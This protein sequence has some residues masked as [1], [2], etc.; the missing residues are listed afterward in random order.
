MK[1]NRH[2]RVSLGVVA[3]GIGTALG[4]LCLATGVVSAY[5]TF[6][7]RWRNGTASFAVNP[8][9]ADASA[10]AASAQIAAIRGGADEWTTNGNANFSWTYAGTTSIATIDVN[11]HVN[12]I[13]AYAADGGSTLAETY[14]ASN[15][16]G[17][18]VGID[19]RFYDNN[20]TW[21][22]GTPAGGEFDIQGVACHE[23][24]HALGLGHSSDPAATMY[25]STSAGATNLR[26]I[27]ADD[28]AGIQSI[29]GVRNPIRID[30]VIAAQGQIRGG[31]QVNVA[32]ANL[33]QSNRVFFGGVEGTVVSSPNSSSL[34]VRTPAGAALGSVD[35]EVR[36][37]SGS[38]TL[39][40]GFTYVANSPGLAYEGSTQAGRT[41]QVV[42]YG[43]P[44][45]RF[46]LVCDTDPG[47]RT[48]Q[49]LQ[50]CVGFSSAF[51]VLNDSLRRSGTGIRLDGRGEGRVPYVVP[52]DPGL[53]LQSITF[54]A[55]V[56]VGVGER[57]LAVTDCMPITVFP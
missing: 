21:A 20:R 2:C 47:P 1:T 17:E 13:Y 38:S 48:R 37:A 56:D 50:L 7:G 53:L 14:C 40:S 57:S 51:R 11:D 45:A 33:A 19:M 23:F 25:P 52:S 26:T 22:S 44:N 5:S 6:C 55:V 42:V 31:T 28:V 27:A 49:G 10:G 4:A 35:V 9:F 12:A 29:Y 32:G 8:N 36:N 54:D 30:S 3:V 16:A 34:V 15:Q 18:I 46:A 39:P 41:I 24:G 43:L